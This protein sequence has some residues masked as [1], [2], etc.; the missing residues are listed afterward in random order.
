M[1]NKAC[2]EFMPTLQ[3]SN[4]L[5]ILPGLSLR[6][7][8]ACRVMA[9]QAIIIEYKDTKAQREGIY[10]SKSSLRLCVFVLNHLKTVLTNTF[11]RD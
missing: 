8:L 10:N 6:F 5:L 7:D 9:L 2:D 3:V 1:S 4:F 11:M